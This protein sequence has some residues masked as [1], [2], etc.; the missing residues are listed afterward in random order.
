MIYTIG[1]S[2]RTLEAFV[3]LLQ[4]HGVRQLADIRLV[5]RSRRWP[6]F[7]GDALAQSLAAVDI[8]YRHFQALG[9]FRKPRPNSH[10]T[11]W[12]NKAFRG[13][14]DYMETAAFAAALEDLLTF[15]GETPQR[16]ALVSRNRGVGSLD[17][18][19]AARGASGH[20]SPRLRRSRTPALFDEMASGP[21]VIMCSEAVWWRCH[22]QLV[23][24]ALLA[25]RANVRHIMS[26]TSA[27]SHTLTEFGETEAGRVRYG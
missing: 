24:D 4:A 23:A 18:G 7:S 27:P 8:T 26:A 12:H 11:A 9:G 25:R 14:A 19:A 21:T 2:T 22:R 17:E 16:P 5:A 20:R 15:A 1:H 3:A 6:H 10:N 13:Y